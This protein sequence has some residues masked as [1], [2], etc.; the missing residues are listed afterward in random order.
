MRSPHDECH[1]VN[2]TNYLQFY[3]P[4][5]AITKW[6]SLSSSSRSRIFKWDVCPSTMTEIFGRTLSPSHS[7]SLTPGYFA[8]SEAIASLTLEP[9]T[10]TETFP[11]VSSLSGAGMKMVGM[12]LFYVTLPSRTGVLTA[13]T[14]NEAKSL[15]YILS[16]NI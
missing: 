14:V 7:L 10:A 9:D 3:P 11:C 13:R 1:E 6:T 16:T 2:L 12:G 8:S 5:I 15:G 4:L